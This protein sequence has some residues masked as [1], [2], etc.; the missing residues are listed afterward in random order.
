MSGRQRQHATPPDVGDVDKMLRLLDDVRDGRL[1]TRRALAMLTDTTSPTLQVQRYRD[2]HERRYGAGD[3]THEEYQRSRLSDRE[4]ELVQ[5]L[6]A[7]DD[8]AAYGGPCCRP[9]KYCFRRVYSIVE[10]FVYAFVFLCCLG[11]LLQ[12]LRFAW[13]Y[14]WAPWW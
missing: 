2:E 6:R 3:N 8:R 13:P 1:D 14:L 5:L 9:V 10:Y 4:R 11:F 12:A 7:V